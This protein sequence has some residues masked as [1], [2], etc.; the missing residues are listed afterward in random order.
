MPQKIASINGIWTLR[1]SYFKIIGR[2]SRPAK[3]RA[4]SQLQ[5]EKEAVDRKKKYVTI[6]F[7]DLGP[8]IERIIKI[9]PAVKSHFVEYRNEPLHLIDKKITNKGKALQL[10][11]WLK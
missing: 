7:L 6:K 1:V 9:W 5:F 8:T 4:D 11:F 10:C 2:F 3:R